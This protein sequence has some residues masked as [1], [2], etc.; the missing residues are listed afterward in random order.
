[1]AVLSLHANLLMDIIHLVFI[2]FIV[3]TKPGKVNV[4]GHYFK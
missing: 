3:V 2:W 1:M 4:F